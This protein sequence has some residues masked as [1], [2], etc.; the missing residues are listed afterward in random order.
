MKLVALA[1]SSRVAVDLGSAAATTERTLL[2]S[3]SQLIYSEQTQPAVR[4]LHF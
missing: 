2:L 1:E 3:L 4:C